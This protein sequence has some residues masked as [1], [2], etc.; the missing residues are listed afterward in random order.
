MQQS[1][2]Q[3]VVGLVH[4]TGSLG[5]DAWHEWMS[6]FGSEVLPLIAKRL[7]TARQTHRQ[8]DELDIAY[9]KLIA[10]LRWL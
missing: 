1:T 3:E 9:E 8:K 4:L 7:R 10:D 2:V 5:E 6:E